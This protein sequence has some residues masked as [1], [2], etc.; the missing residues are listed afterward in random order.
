MT[1]CSS[2]ESV[3]AAMRAGAV[4]Y[5]IKPVPET[6]L[7]RVIRAAARCAEPDNE[8]QP[9]VTAPL[10]QSVVWTDLLDLCQRIAPAQRAKVL[11]TGESGSGKDVVARYI[12]AL[13]PRR[14]EPCIVVNCACL[15]TELAEAELFGHEAGAFT[16]ARGRRKGVLELADGGTLFLDEIGELTLAMQAKLLRVLEDQRFRRI[17]AENEISVDV[18]FIFATNQPLRQRAEDGLFRWDLYQRLAVLELA[19]PP[20]R[21]RP[22]DTRCLIEGL[23]P[24]IAGSFASQ[25]PRVDASAWPLINAYEWP[26]NVRELRNFLE[27]AVVMSNGTLDAR[28][29]R[30]LLP[31]APASARPSVVTSDDSTAAMTVTNESGEPLDLAAATRLHCERTLLWAEGNVSLAARQLG[32]SRGTLR[33]H[34]ND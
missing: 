26:G 27:R 19:L 6:Q 14:N 30:Q 22:G 3:V 25:T 8:Q 29:V 21:E 9:E 32:V 18:R 17:G 20:I 10:G 2:T 11:I 7:I 1:G 5:L 28:V 23:L 31:R 15:S 24:V 4:D 33:R 16:G 13:S 12:H 34:L